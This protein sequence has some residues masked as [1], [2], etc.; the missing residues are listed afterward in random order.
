LVLD[1][2]TGEILPSLSEAGTYIVTYTIAAAGGCDEFKTTT[3]VTVIAIPSASIYYPGSPYC[4]TNASVSVIL[5]G[6]PGGTF[7]VTPDGL[8]I[9]SSTGEIYPAASVAGTYTI[10][11]TTPDV[12]CGVDRASYVVT[13]VQAPSATISYNGTPFCPTD[14]LSKPIITGSLG[15]TFTVAPGGLSINSTTG[16]INPR[17]SSTGTYTITYTIPAYGGCAEFVTT[18]TVTIASSTIV[19][20]S[21][22]DQIIVFPANAGFGVKA[23]GT[24]LSYQWQENNGSGWV[25]LTNGGVYSGVFTDSLRLASPPV[26]MSGYKYRVIVSGFCA[27]DAISDEA[28]LIVTLK[29]FVLKITAEGIDKMYDGN[30]N[31]TVTLSDNR[32]AG[33]IF[34]VNYTNATFDTK[35]VGTDKPVFVSGIT[36]SGPDAD[37]Y[38]YNTT[39]TTTADITPKPITVTATP[40]LKKIYGDPDPAVFTYSF[41]PDLIAGDFFM[42]LLTRVPGENPGLYPILQGSLT[43]GDN[44]TIT[45]I[46]NLFE[47]TYKS[48][49]NVVVSAGQSKMYGDPDPKLTYTYYPELDPG[50]FFTGELAR[51]PGENVGEYLINRGT[52]SANPKY[53]ITMT[54]SYF[55]IIPK[56]ITVTG[57]ADIKVYDGNTSSDEIP[58][59]T[60]NLA[61]DDTGSFTQTYDTKNVGTGKTMTPAGHVNDGN[62]GLNYLVTLVSADLGIITPKPLIGSITASDKYYDGTIAATILTRTLAGVISGDDVRYV[63]GTATFDTPTVGKDKPVAGVGFSLAGVDAGNYTVNENADTKA[64]ILVL[65]VPTD[66]TV[67]ASTFTHY[68]DLVTLTATVYGGAP[69]AGGPQAAKTVSF[70]IEGR[71]IRDHSNNANIPLTISGRNLVATITVSILETTYTGSLAPGV[72]EAAAYFNEENINYKLVPNPALASFEFRPGFTILVY[73]NPSPGPVNFKISVDVGA[74]VVL[75]LYADNGQLVA[76]VFEGFIA[77]GEAKIIPFKGYLAQGIYRYRVRIGNEVKVGNVI[78]IGVY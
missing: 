1:P 42:G 56:P 25:N 6:T 3:E 44:Y 37:K 10:T 45:Y 8:S 69:L 24:A 64:D 5:T 62:N 74:V 26:S 35:N 53:A 39:T 55:T 27:P 46:S 21:P 38:E 57:V 72:K 32:Q 34:T 28:I 60:P 58:V 76:R 67:N 30:T 73:P 78:I 49:I 18:T 70:Y 14:P 51:A 7:T 52:L 77:T 71:L 75:E 33:D 19:T 23:T 16:V 20:T 63:G 40:G 17:L 9:D 12:R 43:L 15:G 47:I 48:T 66:L 59:I 22:K 41:T 4:T 13:V 54:T 65:V 2:D 31:A 11:Y 50:D 29:E 61:F 68:S 36:I